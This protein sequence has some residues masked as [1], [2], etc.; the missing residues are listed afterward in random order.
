MIFITFLSVAAEGSFLRL[1]L[2][3]GFRAFVGFCRAFEVNAVDY[4]MKPVN[5]ERFEQPVAKLLSPEN[6]IINQPPSR[7]LEYDDRLF[8]NCG[9]RSFFLKIN[10]VSHVLSS[11]NYTEVFTIKGQKFLTEKPFREWEEWVP[12]K[13]FALIHRSCMVNLECVERLES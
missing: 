8:L 11:G 7:P 2:H 5:P 3:K 1:F 10:T 13:H 4:L 6:N 9:S 12:E